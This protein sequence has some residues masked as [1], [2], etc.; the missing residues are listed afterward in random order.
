VKA[1]RYLVYGLDVE[2]ELAL[3][4][5]PA[6]AAGDSEPAIRLQLGTADFFTRRTRD[7]AFVNGDWIQQIVMA[8]G[9]VY[10]WVK[11]VLETIVTPDGRVATC[12][13]MDGVDRHAFEAN[14]LNFVISVSLTLLGEEP[15]HAT[16]VDLGDRTVG[17]LG[18]SGAGKSTLAAYLIGQGA[19]LVTDDMLRLELRDDGARVHAGPYRLKLM[20]ET[21]ERLLPHAAGRGHFNEETEKLLVQPCEAVPERRHR[22]LDALFWLGKPGEVAAGASPSAR[23][24]GGIELARV[25]I[26]SA[27]NIRYLAPERLERQMRFAEKVATALPVYALEYPRDFAALDQVSREIRR[28]ALA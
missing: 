20:P 19:D 25:L 9:G 3:S 27:M 1:Q 15:L 5:V 16:V 28:V 2:S 23:R 21:A 26:Y 24:L 8:D 18:P 22:R 13:W 14:L 6:L 12:R 17:L 11:D 7:V 4:T 10:I